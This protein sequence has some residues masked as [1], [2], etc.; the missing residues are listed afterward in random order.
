[1]SIKLF[2]A[3]SALCF[4]LVVTATQDIDIKKDP[5]FQSIV[6]TQNS[7]EYKI[8]ALQAYDRAATQ[9]KASLADKT[10]SADEVQLAA[11]DFAEKKPAIILD[12]DETVL[13]NSA[14]NARNVADGKSYSLPS[15][16]AW[17]NEGKATEIPGSMAFI[18]LAQDQGVEVFYVTNRRDVVKEATLKNLKELGYPVD[19]DHLLTRNDEDGREGDKLSRRAMVA[20][21]HRIVL[22]IG[23]N[24]AD[25]C[26]GM[27]GREQ[28]ARNET[29]LAKQKKLSRG[30]ILLPNPVYGGWERALPDRDEVLQLS[31]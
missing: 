23:D 13:D 17:T 11:N 6:W 26:S 29:A 12:V 5:R 21:E 2:L 20:K 27:D 15:W 4:A 7:A 1:M 31:R 24:M 8:L 14:Y 3:F 9:L 30:W 10:W 22:L 18:K 28:N 25:L 16:N 19:N